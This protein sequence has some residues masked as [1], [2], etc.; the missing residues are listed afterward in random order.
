MD[1]KSKWKLRVPAQRR[2]QRGKVAAQGQRF[3][4]KKYRRVRACRQ[5]GIGRTREGVLCNATV[6]HTTRESEYLAEHRG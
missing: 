3:S 6:A 2:Q 1:L 4:A 5:K